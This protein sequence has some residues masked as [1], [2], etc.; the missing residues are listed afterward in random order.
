MNEVRN[1]DAELVLL[2]Y[3]STDGLEEWIT[4]EFPKDLASG[5]LRRFRYN[6]ASY[7]DRSHSKN[8]TIKLSTGD[9]CCNIDAD[10]YIGAGF[11]AYLHSVF[12]GEEKV[13]I[14]GLSNV[15]N[16]PDCCG[17][18]CG[19]RSDFLSIGGYDENFEGHG[20]EDYDIS[21]RLQLL[22]LKELN[23]DDPEFRRAI[24]HSNLDRV[25]E[26]RLSNLTHRILIDG[27]NKTRTN[28]ILLMNNGWYL[29]CRVVD[30]MESGQQ[31]RF[32]Y[33]LESDSTKTG[34]WSE[35]GSH[36]TMLGG[37]AVMYEKTGSPGHFSYASDD[38]SFQEVGMDELPD[39][40]LFFTQ[41]MNR[42]RATDNFSRRRIKPNET[43]GM[44]TVL[45]IETS[46]SI[47]V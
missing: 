22:G 38:R 19:R 6:G 13:F 3:G 32:R 17:K 5:K 20:F 15:L 1:N 8:L 25:R 27:R 24:S 33:Q 23:L 26:D 35:S 29:S 44:G 12:S 41:I 46:Q 37:T 40:I 30:T 14:S 43:F 42:Y 18:I 31:S 4:S 45:H 2:D 11:S 21:N 47:A 39:M 16:A 7:F 9:V 36:L 34:T 10:N 28:V